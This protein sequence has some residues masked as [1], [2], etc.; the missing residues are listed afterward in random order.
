MDEAEKEHQNEGEQP[1]VL[2]KL[3]KIP[4]PTRISPRKERRDAPVPRPGRD[5]DQR[6]TP[7][8]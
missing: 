1:A 7:D 8:G 5:D 6:I 2:P 3:P 4:D